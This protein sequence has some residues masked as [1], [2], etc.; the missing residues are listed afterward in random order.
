MQHRS[1]LGLHSVSV[2][3]A[4]WHTVLLLP[5]VHALPQTTQTGTGTRGGS[6]IWC[7]GGGEIRQGGLRV[8]VLLSQMFMERM[9][10]ENLN[11]LAGYYDN[12]RRRD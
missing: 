11:R 8:L 3:R 4:T 1:G 5:E 10:Q 7:W 12:L 2:G 9:M 6:R